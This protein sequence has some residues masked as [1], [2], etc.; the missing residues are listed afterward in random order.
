[1]LAIGGGGLLH[2]AARDRQHHGDGGPRADRG[3][4]RAQDRRLQR[5]LRAGPGAGGDVDRRRR[6]RR[7]RARP[8]QAV[9]PRRR[10]DGRHAAGLLHPDRRAS[11]SASCIALAVGL[12]AGLLPAWSAGRS[13]SSKRCGGSRA[14]GLLLL[15]N[16]E[17]V[18]ARWRTTIVADPRHRRDR[19]RVRGHARAGA[20]L[21]G[22]AGHLGLAAQRDGPARRRH[23]GDGQRG[24]PRAARVIEDAPEVARG[25]GRARWSAPRSWWSPRCRCGSRE[26]TPTSRCA[27]CRPRPSRFTAERAAS[28]RDASS[29]P[30]STSW[31]SGR[32]AQASY[33]NLDP[34]QL[35][36]RSAEGTWQVVGIF[37]AGGSSFDS[38][39]W[40]DADLVNRAYQRPLGHLTRRSARA[41]SPPTRSTRLKAAWPPTRACASRSSARPSTTRKASQ[42]DDDADPRARLAW[43]PS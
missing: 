29:S 3:A 40:C 39:V 21:R 9:Q 33:S 16:V 42:H 32:N 12:L 13:R 6:G 23:L 10:S 4:G 26:P 17:S 11:P 36:A 43:S 19:G 41:S 24:D 28:W 15:Y 20:R 25:P 2:A 14:M 34:R 31:S 5:R 27:A 7:P 35:R 22:R 38:E 18:R 37:D 8:R 30:G 1:M